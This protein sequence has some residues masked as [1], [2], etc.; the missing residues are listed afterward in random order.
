MPDHPTPAPRLPLFFLGLAALLFSSCASPR[1]A[2][3]LERI[4]VSP[5]RAGFV[6]RPSGQAFLPW[7]V[8]YGNKGRLLED[9][10]ETEAGTVAD[11]FRKI[12][13]LGANVV[14]LH[15]QLGKFMDGPS[16]P[17]RGAFTRLKGLLREAE[18]G[19]LHLD[20]TGLACYRTSDVP[21]WYDALGE[22][23]RWAAQGVF[24]R[25]L[26]ETCADSDAVF[27]Y[28]LI[29]EPLVPGGTNEAW[30]SGKPFGG[31]D[32]LQRISRSLAGRKRGEL[33]TL[34]I[35]TL[36][37]AI[38]EKDRRHLITV[39]ML[40]WVEGWGHLSGFVPREVA[41]H[42][43]FLS[44]HLYPSSAKPGE[45][46]K[47][48]AECAGQ[49]RPVVIEETFPLSCTGEE[50]AAFLRESRGTACGWIWHY[51]GSTPEDYAARKGPL[52]INEAIWSGALQQ[53]RT[54]GPEFTAEAAAKAQR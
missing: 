30:Y 11:D 34:W 54:L 16:E 14:R 47:A 40:P 35:D 43:D 29:N 3:A 2:C 51:D 6:L 32:F 18:A 46:R 21:A 22:K 28:D 36:T 4:E 52:G 45:V 13:S 26:A 25:T 20:L 48:L 17:N 10:W 49:G 44:V 37:A 15:L 5:D 53:F 12:R 9:F 27:C 23:E 42:V 8:N 50:L 33:A 1:P 41:P 19:G 38:R 31:Y 7:G 24:F 39:G